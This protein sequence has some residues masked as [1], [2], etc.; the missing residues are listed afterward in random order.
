MYDV[1]IKVVLRVNLPQEQA[2]LEA[3]TFLMVAL[4]DDR[5]A[6]GGPRPLIFSDITK[7]LAIVLCKSEPVADQPTLDLW[8]AAAQG[9]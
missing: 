4:S 3:E 1:E 8:T 2:E 7:V 9:D 5:E 6:E